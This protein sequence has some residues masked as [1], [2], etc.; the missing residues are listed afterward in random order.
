MTGPHFLMFLILRSI[1]TLSE[2]FNHRFNRAFN[3]GFNH[4]RFDTVSSTALTM[5]SPDFG[6]HTDGYFQPQSSGILP[7]PRGHSRENQQDSETDTSLE[8]NE[9]TLS[10]AKELNPNIFHDKKSLHLQ[11]GE[12]AVNV[13]ITQTA[14][15]NLLHILKPLHPELPS[16]ARTPLNTPREVPLKVVEPEVYHHFGFNNCI[17]RLMDSAQPQIE[18]SDTILSIDGLPL[19][20]SLGT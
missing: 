7:A 15:S 6:V 19:S 11:L 16:D 2:G 20:K 12:R 3:Y 4:H 13:N 5:M 10:Q 18:I 17:E 1:K 9:D 14:F 8:D